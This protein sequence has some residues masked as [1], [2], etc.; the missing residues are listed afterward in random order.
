MMSLQRFKPELD[1]RID[2]G[3]AESE[4]YLFFVTGGMSFYVSMT[5]I[6]DREL[7]SIL[8][9]SALLV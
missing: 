9:M 7:S 4:P 2:G 8:L 1:E 5:N 3:E 6:L